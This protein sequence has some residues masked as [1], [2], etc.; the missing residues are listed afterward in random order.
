[1]FLYIIRGTRHVI[2]V[3]HYCVVLEQRSNRSR[4]SITLEL[5]FSLKGI[6]QVLL[7]TINANECAVH[8]SE[9]EGTCF[10]M[11]MSYLMLQLTDHCSI[12]SVF[13]VIDSWTVMSFTKSFCEHLKC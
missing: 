11:Q 13:L 2:C 10:G 3:I 8:T 7:S 5:I 1:M 9:L 12:P 4:S 6:F